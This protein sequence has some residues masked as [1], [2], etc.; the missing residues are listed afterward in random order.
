[1]IRYN[2]SLLGM[3]FNHQKEKSGVFIVEKRIAAAAGA[4]EAARG[5]KAKERERSS[6]LGIKIQSGTW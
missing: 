4:A 5:E 1:M 3:K 6:P 2:F